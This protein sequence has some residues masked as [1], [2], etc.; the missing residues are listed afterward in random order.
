MSFTRHIAGVALVMLSIGMLS[1]CGKD[2]VRPAMIQ[3]IRDP[4]RLDGSIALL[5]AGKDKK[6]TKS[7]EA[8]MKK[9][10]ND[11]DMALLLRSINEDP[12]IL[13]GA[14][15]FA[16][17]AQAGDSY[18]TLAQRFLG[19]RLK[20]YALMRYNGKTAASAIV[21]GEIV[22]IPGTKP[23]EAAAPIAPKDSKP[24]AAAI[25][26]PLPG[27]SQPPQAAKPDVARAAK[28][29]SAGLTALARGEVAKA[30]TAFRAAAAA[31]PEDALIK[32]DLARA[33][34]LLKTVRAKG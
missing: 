33:E 9:D 13:L 4:A 6:A 10:P 14:E 16:Y 1:A 11:R 29:R 5:E 21:P 26:K 23:K 3:P 31:S 12:R 8:G 27:K 34:R 15:S 2:Q 19:D 7:L 28:L 30:V 22:R 25:G 32:R 24:R 18:M 20:F 17:S